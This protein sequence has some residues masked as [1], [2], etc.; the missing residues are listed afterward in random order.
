MEVT[1]LLLCGLLV[2]P[3][4][5]GVVDQ[6]RN[7]D[8]YCS[9]GAVIFNFV[10]NERSNHRNFQLEDILGVSTSR[11]LIHL[12]L[13]FHQLKPLPEGISQHTW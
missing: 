4:N 12:L 7:F 10:C 1:E 9:A 11:S 3:T 13:M 6:Q 8:P 5:L 2:L